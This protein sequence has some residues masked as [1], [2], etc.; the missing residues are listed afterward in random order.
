MTALRKANE[1]KAL[2][3]RAIMKGGK[4]K[5]NDVSD[6]YEEADD[7]NMKNDTKNGGGMAT[8][9]VDDGDLLDPLALSEKYLKNQ[10]DHVIGG[11]CDKLIWRA[12]EVREHFRLLWKRECAF[13]RHFFPIFDNV[14]FF[15]VFV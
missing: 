12:A 9:A 7:E 3:E 8:N 5:P 10:L 6:F 1:K 13:L 2:K 4:R 11:K 14:S 15:I